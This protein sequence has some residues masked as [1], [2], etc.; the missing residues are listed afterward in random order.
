MIYIGIDNG[1][2]GSIAIISKNGGHYEIHPTPVFSSQDY[3]KKKK[4]I[5]RV[6]VS[7]FMEIICK[8]PS[9]KKV[10]IERPLVNPKLFQATISAVR[11]LESQMTILEALSIP[12]CFLDSKQW[13][14]ELLPQGCKGTELK[15]ASMDIAIRLFPECETE[16]RKQ[17]DGDGL[18]IA[19]YA[20]RKNL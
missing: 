15:K 11:C 18:L 2:S 20:R 7:E 8:F 12:Y 6:I 19:E 3:T 14:K 9:S 5:N 10:F 17:K 13:Q 4:N 16:I 1:V